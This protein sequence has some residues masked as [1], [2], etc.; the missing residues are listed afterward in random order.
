[1]RLQDQNLERGDDGQE[2]LLS[3]PCDGQ[4]VK[5]LLK[6]IAEYQKSLRGSFPKREAKAKTPQEIADP[7][8]KRR[9]VKGNP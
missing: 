9:R 4:D 1:M 8:A 2:P 6:Q 7:P 3:L 5:V